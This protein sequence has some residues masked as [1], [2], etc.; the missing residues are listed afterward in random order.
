M[1]S[2]GTE[3]I[4]MESVARADEEEEE[5]ETKRSASC[6]LLC[7]NTRMEPL[8]VVVFVLVQWHGVCVLLL[9]L[10]MCVFSVCL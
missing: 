1:Q 9:S 8:R 10:V 5:E 2:V 6:R 3:M 7:V 4:C